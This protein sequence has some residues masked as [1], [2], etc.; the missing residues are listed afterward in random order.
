MLHRIRA[1]R[2]ISPHE[3]EIAWDDGQTGVVDFAETIAKYSVQLVLTGNTH[4][5]SHPE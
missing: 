5:P 2:A 1:V 3:V 4:P